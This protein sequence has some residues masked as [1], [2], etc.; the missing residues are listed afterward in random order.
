MK[1]VADR[2]VLVK[3]KCNG[4]LEGSSS[5]AQYSRTAVSYLRR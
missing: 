2:T 3:R 4:L 5:R 1:E